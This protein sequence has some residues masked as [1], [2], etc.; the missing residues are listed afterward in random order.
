MMQLNGGK[1]GVNG[2]QR[3]F[4]AEVHRAMW[5]PYTM[6]PEYGT[7]EYKTHFSGYGLGWRLMDVKGYLQV[8][9]TGGLAGIVTQV[10]LLPEPDQTIRRW[11][12][13]CRD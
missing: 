3:L 5:T 4:S 12:G 9:H 11:R 8:G 6:I 7:S 13:L 2:E 10:T 1:Y